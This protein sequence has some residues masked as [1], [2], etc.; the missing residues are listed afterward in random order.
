MEVID[1]SKKGKCGHHCPKLTGPVRQLTKSRDSLPSE[2]RDWSRDHTVEGMGS[3]PQVVLCLSHKGC[4]HTCE[5][6][7][8]VHTYI[9]RCNFLGD[10]EY[11]TVVALES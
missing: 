8:S 11:F 3:L 7:H 5:L 6:M 4:V 9:S 2:T 10:I 1:P